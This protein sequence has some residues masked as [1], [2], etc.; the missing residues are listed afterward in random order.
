MQAARTLTTLSNQ[1]SKKNVKNEPVTDGEIN[2]IEH[3]L[4]TVLNSFKSLA[5]FKAQHKDK[6]RQLGGLPI[7]DKKVA[8]MQAEMP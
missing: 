3:S 8:S 6:V 7:D 1:I 2:A 4:Q 5:E